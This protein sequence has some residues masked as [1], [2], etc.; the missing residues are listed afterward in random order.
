MQTNILHLTKDSALV[1]RNHPLTICYRL[2]LSLIT[3]KMIDRH[4]QP[5]SFT[6]PLHT[7]LGDVRKSLNQLMEIF[8]SQFAQ[9][10]TTIGTTHL[11]KIQ[12][13]VGDSEPVLQ[14]PYLITMKYY[15]LVRN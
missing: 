6:I 14:R 15:D 7:L 1:M 11:T 13:D 3:Q 4:V 12:I 5:D 8:K 10:E 9:Y 2:L